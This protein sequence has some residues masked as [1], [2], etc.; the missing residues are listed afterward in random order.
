MT[1]TKAIKIV[2]EKSDSI[3]SYIKDNWE[4]FVTKI[5]NANSYIEFKYVDDTY[6][7]GSSSSGV[8]GTLEVW[9][10]GVDT[11]NNDIDGSEYFDFIATL[12]FKDLNSGSSYYSTYSKIID[13]PK[14]SINAEDKLQQIYEIVRWIDVY[15]HT[16]ENVIN[17]DSVVDTE[18]NEMDEVLQLSD[19]EKSVYD[20]RGLIPL[21]RVCE[22]MGMSALWD[23]NRPG[24]AY[25]DV[26]SNTINDYNFTYELVDGTTYVNKS[27]LESISGNQISIVSGVVYKGG[28]DSE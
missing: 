6:E 22:K 21:R 18:G 1:K 26:N 7:S 25:K 17:I 2:N 23:G 27:L 11:K 20:E 19:I 15:N 28:G 5:Y 16:D 8:D 12:E 9:N 10:Y 13:T 24:I 4:S 3:I 14:N